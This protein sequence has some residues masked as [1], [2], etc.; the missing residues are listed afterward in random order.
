M[1]RRFWKEV[2]VCHLASGLF[3]VQLD[4]RSVRLPA[5][6]ELA[7]RQAA[8][9]SAIAEEWRAIPPDVAFDPGS[10]PLTGIA[11]TMIERIAPDRQ[12]TVTTLL[13]YGA[14][15]LLFYRDA[16]EADAQSAL[17]DPVM[18]RFAAQHGVRPDVTTALAPL[19]AD[20]RLSDE[21]ART[22]LTFDDAALASLGVLTPALGSLVLGIGLLEGWLELETACAVASFEERSQM[23][24]WG[25]DVDVLDQLAARARDVDDAMRFYELSRP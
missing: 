1:R 20:P 14:S 16:A 22:L 11:G 21:F 25:E 4:G 19:P 13:S 9:A 7:V 12:A 23:Q 8:L 10:L 15:D 2:T 17:F 6:H 3:A 5:G 18:D 24:R